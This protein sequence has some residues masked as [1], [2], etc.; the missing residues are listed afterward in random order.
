MQSVDTLYIHC[1]FWW[2]YHW[3]ITNDQS[4][5]TKQLSGATDAY[6]FTLTNDDKDMWHHMVIMI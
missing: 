1:E 4:A 6:T 2:I 5:S 3:V